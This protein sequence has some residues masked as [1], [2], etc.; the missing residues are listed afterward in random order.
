LSNT[1]KA[2]KE[3]EHVCWRDFVDRV[4]EVF[5]KKHLEKDHTINLD[6]VRL[7]TIYTRTEP[8][9]NDREVV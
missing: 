2:P 1:F 7:Q 4:D 8:T 9:A 6:D 5:T 3:G